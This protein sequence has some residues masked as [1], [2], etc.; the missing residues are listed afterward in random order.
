MHRISGKGKEVPRINLMLIELGES[1]HYCCVKRVS[2]LLFDQSKN[3]KA[4][5][6]CVMCLTG[7]LREDLLEN[8][9]KYCNSLVS[10]TPKESL[11]I[12]AAMS[13]GSDLLFK[14]GIM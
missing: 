3:R 10:A 9:K 12:T 6:Y 1:Q 4:K 14:K 13:K 2:A 8:H 7:F 5:H 11:K